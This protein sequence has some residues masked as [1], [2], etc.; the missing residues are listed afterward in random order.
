[1]KFL[2]ILIISLSIAHAAETSF[3]NKAC[4][5]LN[6]HDYAN[7]K[8]MLEKGI[9]NNEPVAFRTLGLMYINGD[10]V[11]KNYK[12][13]LDYFQ[14]A[15]KHGYINAAYD[16]GVMYRNGEGITKN[17]QTAKKYYLIA[18]KNNYPLA[19]F[20]LAKIYAQEGDIQ[21]FKIWVEKALHNGYRPRTQSDSAIID[22]FRSLQG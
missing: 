17:R 16:I 10:G 6:K 9:K 19:Q 3:S 12:L 8:Q 2:F 1:M 4:A 7:A 15:F 18:A 11:Q 21:N 13:A 5:F 14:Q 20:E 22:Y